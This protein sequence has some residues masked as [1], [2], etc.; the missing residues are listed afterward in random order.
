MK[1]QVLVMN[2]RL[3]LISIILRKPIAIFGL[4]GKTWSKSESYEIK[5]KFKTE[6]G[7]NLRSYLFH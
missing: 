7:L 1:M 2:F 4:R 5:K 3:V 6:L